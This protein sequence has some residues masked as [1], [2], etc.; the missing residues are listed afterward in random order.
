MGTP[1][2]M[3][4]FSMLPTSEVAE[5]GDDIRRLFEELSESLSGARRAYSGE[6]RPAL[7]VLEHDTAVEVVVEATGI[8]AAALRILFR[9]GVLLIVGEKAPRAGTGEGTVHL[10]EREFGRFARA[11]RL[12]GAFDL[13]NAEATL[14]DG[15]LTVRLPK[16]EDRRG[17]PHHIAITQAPRRP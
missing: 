6:C 1:I 14:R 12:S 5:L 7:D 8:P 11:V 15:E 2:L 3:A 16:R 9:G 17:S 13:A 10:L 4:H